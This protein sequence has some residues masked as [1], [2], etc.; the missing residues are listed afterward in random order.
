MLKVKVMNMTSPS[1]KEVV[2]QFIIKVGDTTYFQSYDSI[3]AIIENDLDGY[4]EA[5]ILDENKWDYS[6]TT[7]KYRNIFLGEDKKET[8]KKINSGKYE[9]ANL[10]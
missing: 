1:G 10:N 3:I 5:I 8:Q 6:T 7:G 4:P 9:L 2:N